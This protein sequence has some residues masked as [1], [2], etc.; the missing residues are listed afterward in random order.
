MSRVKTSKLITQNKLSF[1]ILVCN[2]NGKDG[3]RDHY[4]ASPDVTPTFMQYW[5]DSSDLPP[6]RENRA[7]LYSES[8]WCHRASTLSSFSDG[9]NYSA[10]HSIGHECKGSRS[11]SNCWLA[12][13]T[14]R[15]SGTDKSCLRRTPSRYRPSWYNPSEEPRL[16]TLSLKI[17][18][19]MFKKRKPGHMGRTASLDYI[20]S[21]GREEA[22]VTQTTTHRIAARY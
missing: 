15:I 4:H 5:P 16:A 20:T 17:V 9:M 1:A 14:D 12:N 8:S 11:L 21:G 18:H 6:C 13:R 19:K 2:A 10:S 7:P 22:S 3:L